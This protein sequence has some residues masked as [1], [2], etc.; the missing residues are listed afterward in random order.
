MG[1]GFFKT[2]K[3]YLE[4]KTF[5]L[6]YVDNASQLSASQEVVIDYPYVMDQKR[7]VIGYDD[8]K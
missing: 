5:C 1:R 4:D 3:R 6:L 7:R 2:L 8:R